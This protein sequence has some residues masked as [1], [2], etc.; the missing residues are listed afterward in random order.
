MKIEDHHSVRIGCPVESPW[1]GTG[2]IDGY[3]EEA[4]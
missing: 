3:M 2:G 1:D 4:P